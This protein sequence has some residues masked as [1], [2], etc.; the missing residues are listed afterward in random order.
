MGRSRTPRTCRKSA[1]RRGEEEE[2][3]FV[4]R[5]V[6]KFTSQLENSDL[7]RM[8]MGYAFYGPRRINLTYLL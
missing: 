1:T 4:P 3:D 2:A 7:E 5:T 8:V 6:E